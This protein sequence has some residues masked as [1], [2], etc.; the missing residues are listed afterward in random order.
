LRTFE[1]AGKIWVELSCL[2]CWGLRTPRLGLEL[3]QDEA[4]DSG[5]EDRSE[6]A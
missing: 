3:V 4:K 5:E 1:L 6:E 2:T